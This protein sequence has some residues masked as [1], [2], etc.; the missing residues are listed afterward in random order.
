MINPI[1]RRLLQTLIGSKFA[2]KTRTGSFIRLLLIPQ[3]IAPLLDVEKAKIV[4]FQG[5]G[6]TCRNVL[7]LQRR[8]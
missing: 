8:D 6:I 3:I 4:V 5:L 1:A 2:F 7:R